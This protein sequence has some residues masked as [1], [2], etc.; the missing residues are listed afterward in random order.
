MKHKNKKNVTLIITSFICLIIMSAS[1]AVPMVASEPIMDKVEEQA[2]LDRV[3]N[4]FTSI[5]GSESSVFEKIQHVKHTFENNSVRN[6]LDFI[7]FTLISLILYP[8]LSLFPG[9]NA[10]LTATTLVLFN[11]GFFLLWFYYGLVFEAFFGQDFSLV[12]W[13]MVFSVLTFIV[14]WISF[15]IYPIAVYL[16]P[17]FL[18]Y[19]IANVLRNFRSEEIEP[20]DNFQTM[21]NCC[22][23]G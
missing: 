8:L 19:L 11:I 5:L 13:I 17:L 3:V 22:P 20:S 4:D 18:S 6:L 16:Q 15:L 23:L 9:L 14:S 1:T 10:F 2:K 7:L 21:V 12:E